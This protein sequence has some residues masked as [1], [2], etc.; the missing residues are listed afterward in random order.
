MQAAMRKL[1]NS[2]KWR[3]QDGAL[4]VAVTARMSEGYST[5]L[6]RE[7][8]SAKKQDP[9]KVTEIWQLVPVTW[10]NIFRSEQAKICF[11]GVRG[12]VNTR[13]KR[14]VTEKGRQ[15]CFQRR[16]GWMRNGC[17]QFLHAPHHTHTSPPFPPCG[18]FLHEWLCHTWGTK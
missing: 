12:W 3:V 4:S 14:C 7:Y 13:R 10:G 15:M 18:S 9:H 2:L 16:G 6:K 17:Q 5:L 1:C 11:P 8:Q